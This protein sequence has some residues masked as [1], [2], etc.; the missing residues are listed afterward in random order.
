MLL[1]II[2]FTLLLLRGCTAGSDKE[3][4]NPDKQGG[5]KTPHSLKAHKK[6][7]LREKA[8]FDG[9]LEVY[10]TQ[11]TKFESENQALEQYLK[12]NATYE[13][14]DLEKVTSLLEERFGNICKRQNKAVDWAF[15]SAKID[16]KCE[17]PV[18]ESDEQFFEREK[19]ESIFFEPI[20]HDNWNSINDKL[21][22]N[23]DRLENCT[24]VLERFHVVF[25]FSFGCT[26]KYCI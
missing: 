21:E 25:G 9:M 4:T 22:E 7:L 13:V 5:K 8:I 10:K 11:T 1:I 23:Y 19:P 14:A 15:D 17:T 18:L 26:Y 6:V 24:N 2:G 16:Y 12:K 3:A 20:E